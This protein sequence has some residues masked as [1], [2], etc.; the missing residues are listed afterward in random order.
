[1]FTTA[2]Y[3]TCTEFSQVYAHLLLQDENTPEKQ[4]KKMIRQAVK[5]RKKYGFAVPKL[6]GALCGESH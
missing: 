1:M 6:P 3:L 4:L 2:Q 5:Q